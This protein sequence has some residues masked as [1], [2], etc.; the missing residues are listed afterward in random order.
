[1][2][3]SIWKRYGFGWIT[4]GLFVFT[5]AGH[6]LFGWFEYVEEQRAH[7]QAVQAGQ[8]A[9]QML[10]DTLENWQ[11]EFLQLL[12]QVVGLTYFLYIGSP[13]SKEE[14]DRLEEKLDAILRKVDPSNANRLIDELNARYPGRHVGPQL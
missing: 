13:Q 7:G 4:G 1:M 8:F 5:L 10:R 12:W 9:V 11:S 2:R 6:W 3:I 14:D